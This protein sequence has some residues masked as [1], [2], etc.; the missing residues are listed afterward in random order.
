[1]NTEKRN[2][3]K[4]L[5]KEQFPSIYAVF[6]CFLKYYYYILVNMTRNLTALMVLFQIK[7]EFYLLSGVG[8]FKGVFLD[9]SGYWRANKETWRW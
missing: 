1:V 6:P 7:V 8:T 9:F 4:H 5:L 3:S 2:T